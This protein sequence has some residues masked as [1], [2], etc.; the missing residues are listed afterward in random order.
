MIVEVISPFN[1][2]NDYVRKLNLYEQFKVKEY[3]IVNPMRK[4]IHI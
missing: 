4:N 3:W 1:P 2:S